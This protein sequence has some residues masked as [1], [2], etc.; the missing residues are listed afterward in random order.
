[1]TQHV[2]GTAHGTTSFIERDPGQYEGRH[3][4][5]PGLHPVEWLLEDEG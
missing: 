3:R 5:G 2:L 4:H 1:M